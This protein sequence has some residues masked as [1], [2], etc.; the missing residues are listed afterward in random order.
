[1]GKYEEIMQRVR[2]K[3]FE[4]EVAKV[5]NEYL[6][7]FSESAGS[8]LDSAKSQ[9]DGLGHGNA[10]QSYLNR[11]DSY[12]D[13]DYR[14][15]VIQEWNKRNPGKLDQQS[16]S[17][18]DSFG[19]DSKG[20]LDSFYNAKDFFSLFESE[21][22]Y[23]GWRRKEDFI[24]QYLADPEKA[25]SAM[26]YE[27]GWLREAQYRLD[28]K[29]LDAKDFP[30][31][32]KYRS[33]MADSRWDRAWSQYNMGYNDLTYEFINNQNNIRD[34]ILKKSRAYNSDSLLRNSDSV[35]ERNHYE[36][37]T[38]EE[39]AIY[40]YYYAKEGKKRAEAFLDTLSGTLEARSNGA[41]VENV[42]RIAKEH[43]FLAS[44][45]SV[46]TSLGSGFEYAEDVLRFGRDKLIGKD[47]RMGTNE[48]GLMTNA[49]RGTVSDMVDWEIG[50]WDAF[51]FVYSTVM[52]GA[53]SMTSG[54]LGG[55]GGLVLGLSAAAQ[56]TNDA[57]QRGM[58]S[59]KAS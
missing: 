18:L 24:N 31:Y 22:A 28:S 20:I 57:L 26:D 27:D 9:Y 48:L 1:M 2:E 8:Y 32:S 42:S 37:M 49:V 45:A 15:R 17:W 21:D 29:V 25:M 43:P 46:G 38:E 13:L 56:G 11:R 55:A 51:D 23:N 54:M 59:D 35:Y 36:F 19:R 5:D 33:T 16:A 40:N 10:Y 34:E 6:R 47:A 39:V 12:T 44:A 14:R 52:S 41:M 58:S 30:G 7:R 50:N 3:R 53:D 4:Q